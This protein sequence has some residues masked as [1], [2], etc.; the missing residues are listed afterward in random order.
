MINANV[1]RELQVTESEHLGYH[2]TRKWGS[3]KIPPFFSDTWKSPNSCT[4]LKY[5]TTWVPS[6]MSPELFIFTAFMCRPT[7][8]FVI[9]FPF[10]VSVPSSFTIYLLSAWHIEYVL[11]IASSLV[12]NSNQKQGF[13]PF[14]HNSVFS[15]PWTVLDRATPSITICWKYE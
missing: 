5:C 6:Q 2:P 15:S 4:L 9:F 13:R 12:L 8:I 10:P 1:C 11:I 3:N 14:S 7:F